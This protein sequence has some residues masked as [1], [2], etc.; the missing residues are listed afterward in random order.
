[1]AAD[2]AT[3]AWVE[4]QLYALLGA[5]PAAAALPPAAAATLPLAAAC[6]VRCLQTECYQ[7]REE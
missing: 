6:C 5:P 2:K 3:R 4:D 1:M 7:Q